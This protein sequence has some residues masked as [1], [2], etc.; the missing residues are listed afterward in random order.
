[1]KLEPELENTDEDEEMLQWPTVCPN[2]REILYQ[3]RN[4]RKENNILMKAE[5]QDMLKDPETLYTEVLKL[6]TKVQN[7]YTYRENYYKQLYKAK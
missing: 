5:F 4:K 7:L 1:M 3:K 6:I 2:R